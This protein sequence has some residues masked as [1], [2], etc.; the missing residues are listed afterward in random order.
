MHVFFKDTRQVKFLEILTM[1]RIL[2]HPKSLDP[3]LATE[4][5][6][7]LAGPQPYLTTSGY[8]LSHH[9]ST[10]GLSHLQQNS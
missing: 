1:R 8:F 3:Q 6:Y 7:L 4:D 9:L 5:Q 2:S 10:E